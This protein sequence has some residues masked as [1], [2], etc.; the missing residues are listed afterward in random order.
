MASV[1][2]CVLCRCIFALAP[3]SYLPIEW[4]TRALAI[5]QPQCEFPETIPTSPIIIHTEYEG[6]ICPGKYCLQIIAQWQK[7]QGNLRINMGK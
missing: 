7:F 2:V 6:F 3:L 1:C 5:S 4:S